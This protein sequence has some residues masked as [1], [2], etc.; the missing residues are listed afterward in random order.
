MKKLLFIITILFVGIVSYGQNIEKKSEIIITNPS[1]DIMKYYM[2]YSEQDYMQIP[3]Y[4]RTNYQYGT[5]L[6]RTGTVTIIVGAISSIFGVAMIGVGK[7][8]TGGY[9]A[10]GI[11]ATMISVSI[12]LFSFGTHTKRESNVMFQLYRDQKIQ[13]LNNR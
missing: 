12:P 4:I 3:L 6:V 5:N 7:N 11:G 9:V 8:Y 1:W 13:M 2:I 10:L